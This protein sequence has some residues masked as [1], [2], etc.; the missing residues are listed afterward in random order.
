MID[1]EEIVVVAAPKG[2]RKLQ[3]LPI[4]VT[5]LSQQDMQANQVDSTESLTALMPNIFISDYDSRLTSAIYIHRINSHINMPSV[6]LYAD[7]AP[8]IGRSTFSFN[9]ADIERIDMLRGSQ[10]TLYGRDTM[11]GL[12]KVH[13]RSPFSYQGTGLRLDAGSYNNYNAPVAHYHR[14][15]NQS[16]SSTGGFYKY[17]DGSFKNTYLNRRVGRS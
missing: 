12:I 4:A 16:A 14:I 13:T 17:G 7:N 11:G 5:V 9:Y 6:G 8:Y 1:I 3:E 2:N 10:G 15:S